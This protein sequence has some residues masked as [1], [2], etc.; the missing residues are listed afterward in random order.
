MEKTE[1]TKYVCLSVKGKG[2]FGYVL[3]AYDKI[4]DC[5]VAIKRTHK[6]GRK[7]SREYQM[8][9]QLT[10][11]PYVAK[12][13]RIFYSL[14]DSN[15]L[16]QNMVFEYLPQDLYSFI[17]N[18]D[19]KTKFMPRRD[20]TQTYQNQEDYKYIPFTEIKRITKE[21]LMGLSYCH[22]RRIVH[23]DLKPENILLTSKGQVKIC[24]FGSSKYIEPNVT[25]STPYMVSRYYRAPEL[26]LGK[27][28]Y[29]PEIDIFAAGCIF[30]EMFRREVI[31]NGETEGE[32]I[33][34]HIDVMGT[35]DQRYFSS[36][37]LPS[38]YKTDLRAMEE[39]PSVDFVKLIDTDGFYQRELMRN[40][41]ETEQTPTELNL[42]AD[43][44]KKMLC[45]D[46]AQRISAEDA[47]RHPFFS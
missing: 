40:R 2:A 20:M 12:L 43:L 18:H 10:E 33:F 41:G 3:E 11:C 34:R 23:R 9:R 17:Y 36:F 38:N 29:G 7:L 22:Q 27:V 6:V 1:M 37:I 30:A 25:K 45:L 14:N 31:F 46:P 13:L 8:L 42:A 44:L 39:K 26:I 24:D 4:H 15:V 19:L 16:I 47:L 35:P 5:R 32:Q 21:L 28:T